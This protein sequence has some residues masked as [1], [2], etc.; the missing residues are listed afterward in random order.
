M[1]SAVLIFVLCGWLASGQTQP[2]SDAQLKDAIAR[3]QSGDFSGAIEGYQRFLEVRPEVTGVRSNLGA[4][5]AHEGRFEDAIREYSLALDADP[6]KV[7]VRLNLGLAFYKSGQMLEAIQQFLKVHA[8]D[9]SNRQATLVLANAY[10]YIGE[11][12]KVIELLEPMGSEG[13]IARL[14][15]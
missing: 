11:N 5:L 3:H 9:P 10:R 8:A 7:S 13:A 4:A 14:A 12:K 2:S 15:T 1:S 6:H